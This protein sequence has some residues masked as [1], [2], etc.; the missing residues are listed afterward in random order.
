MVSIKVISFDMDGIL[1][2]IGLSILCGLREYLDCTPL[3]REFYYY[4]E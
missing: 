3:R 1:P 2:I 4:L